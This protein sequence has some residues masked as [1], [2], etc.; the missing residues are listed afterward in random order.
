MISSII[1]SIGLS[2]SAVVVLSGCAGLTSKECNNAD[3]VGVGYDI[4]EQG[5]KQKAFDEFVSQ[6]SEFNVTPNKEEFIR[7]YNEGL[8]TYCTNRNGYEQGKLNKKYLKVC[9]S[10]LEA[11]FMEGYKTGKEE[12][13][14]NEVLKT[15]QYGRRGVGYK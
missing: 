13:R 6:C 10:N 7:G 9:P 8:E 2:I 14:Q 11:S 5:Q 1:K 12:Y 4:G 15:Q 3:W